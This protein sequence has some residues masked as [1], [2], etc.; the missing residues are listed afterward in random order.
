LEVVSL[1]LRTW[2][3]AV[4]EKDEN[5]ETPLKF[6]CK[7]NAS[8]EV[9]SLVLGTWPDAVKE[10]NKRFATPLHSACLNN[11]PLEVISLL[12]RTWADAVKEKDG[13]GFLPL[14]SACKGNASFDVVSL[15][16]RTWPDAAKEW[17]SM[18]QTPLHLA[19]SVRAHVDVVSILLR[20]WPDAAEEN[21]GM[22]HTPLY[23]AI[24]YSASK[25]VVYL[26]L[27]SWPDALQETDDDCYKKL[28]DMAYHKG[29][30]L[31]IIYFLV[32]KLL[33]DKENRDN[34][35]ELIEEHHSTEELCQCA[36][37][38]LFE[39]DLSTTHINEIKIFFINNEMWNCVYWLIDE[40]PLVSKSMGLHTNEMGSFLSLVGKHCSLLTMWKVILNEQELLKAV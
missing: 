33:G 13:C 3:D 39:S 36:F 14:H 37:S 1:V 18:R 24:L 31:E 7:N 23:K 17:N 2:P 22:G 5:G 29:A 12:L 20:S 34:F 16:L 19:C 28:V 8:L 4:K 25:E 32:D 10:K 21:D 11:A 27:S 9:I 26:L 30:P 15:L 6:A 40:Y 35:F 38:L